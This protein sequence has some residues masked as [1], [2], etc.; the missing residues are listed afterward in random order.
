[1]YLKTLFLGLK[2][3]DFRMYLFSVKN[4]HEVE[5]NQEPDLEEVGPFS[6][7]EQTERVNEVFS[8]VALW[9]ALG[10][11]TGA[12][13]YSNLKDGSSVTYETRKMWHYLPEESLPLDTTVSS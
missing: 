6:Y 8:E 10:L 11:S 7:L 12:W 1:M 5:N 13:H 4:P 2:N 9:M 3:N